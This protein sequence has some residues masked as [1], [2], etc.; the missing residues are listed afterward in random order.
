MKPAITVIMPVL[1]GERYIGQAIESI[2]AQTFQ[3]FELIVVDD[4]STDSTREHLESFER[5][6]RLKCIRHASNQGIPR[7]INDGLR[8]AAGDFIAFLDHDDEWFPEFLETQL[9]YLNSHP[10]TGMAHS[11]FQTIDGVGNILEASVADARNRTRPSG[12]VFRQL[13]RD[14]F[15]VGNSVLIR[16]G[17]FDRVGLFDEEIRWADYH[18]WMRIS[19]AYPV[20][21]VPKVLTKYRQHEGQHTRTLPVG[22][23]LEESVPQTT[24]RRLLERHPEIRQEL[25]SAVVRRRM[26]GLYF[27]MA[28]TWY[29]HGIFRNARI[30]LRKAV[31]LWPGDWRYWALYG[32]CLLGPAGG[33]SLKEA[34][35]RARSLV[36]GS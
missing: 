12:R 24:I 34:Y 35:R 36:A 33:R 32:T 17:C 26:A 28:F 31:G 8:E 7:S 25:G 16:K 29:T 18:M 1:N 19:R 5:R 23:P 15:I 14:N 2:L 20:D 21:Y 6:M 27:D 11:D 13:F 4:G 10:E 3:D 9:N 30:C 22:D